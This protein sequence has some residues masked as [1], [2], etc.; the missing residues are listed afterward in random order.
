MNLIQELDGIPKDVHNEWTFKKKWNH[1]LFWSAYYTF[2]LLVSGPINLTSI[3]INLVFMLYSII[4]VYSIIYY[5]MPK[6][7]YK[8]RYVLFAFFFGFIILLCAGLLGISLYGLFILRGIPVDVFFSFPAI[9]G[10]TIG[11]VGTSVFFLVMYKMV[12]DYITSERKNKILEHQKTE[13]ELK[14]LKSQLNPHFLF[15]ALNNIYF[16]IKKDPDVAAESLAKFSDMMRYQLYECNEDKILLSQEIAYIQNY[17]RINALGK[18]EST[19]IEVEVGKMGAEI[20]ISPF[21]LFPMIENAFKHVSENSTKDNFIKLS[22]QQKDGKLV[23]QTINSYD[24]LASEDLMDQE[25]SKQGGVGMPNL[26]RRLSLMY[27]GN[28]RLEIDSDDN[29]YSTTLEL[30]L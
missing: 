8:Q 22:I 3:L 10:P 6:Y 11:S 28:H 17:I 19:S 29:I 1:I 15:N 26:K 21:M 2:W 27:P 5:F 30:N 23:C 20:M 14:Y 4:A 13:N 16:L 9:L 18:E 24:N 25:L 12:K 7:L